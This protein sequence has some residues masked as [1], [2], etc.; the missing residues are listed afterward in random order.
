M[1]LDSAIIVLFRCD[2]S[3]HLVSDIVS[4]KAE[5]MV[6]E[7]QRHLII[8]IQKMAVSVSLYYYD[9][10]T[11]KDIIPILCLKPIL[12][13]ASYKRRACRFNISFREFGFPSEG[14]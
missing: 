3:C 4:S 9:E 12:V 7:E 5:L 10:A 14:A 1:T 13:D 8:L 2:Y 11:S 6:R